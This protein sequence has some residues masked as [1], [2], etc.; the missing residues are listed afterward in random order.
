MAAYI[1]RAQALLLGCKDCPVI[2]RYLCELEDVYALTKH[3]LRLAA[4]DFQKGR[5]ERILCSIPMVLTTSISSAS[6]LQTLDGIG[7]LL[8]P[9][10]ASTAPS[11][12]RP[13]PRPS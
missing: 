6:R 5:T 7:V 4:D 2:L 3:I 9:L 13:T 10:L 1:S 11:A 8:S 12:L